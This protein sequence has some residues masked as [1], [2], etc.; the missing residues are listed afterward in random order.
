MP[1]ITKRTFGPPLFASI[2]FVLAIAAQQNP[3]QQAGKTQSVKPQSTQA[4][5][6]QQNDQLRDQLA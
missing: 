4:T 3:S 2:R 6:Q 1:H 5:L